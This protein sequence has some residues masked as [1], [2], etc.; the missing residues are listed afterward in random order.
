MTKERKKEI[1]QRIK[2]QLIEKGVLP[3]ELT[4]E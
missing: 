3:E 1:V 2:K 4:E